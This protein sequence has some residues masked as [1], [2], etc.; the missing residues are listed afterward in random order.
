MTES[1]I[2]HRAE[3]LQDLTKLS[4]DLLIRLMEKADAS[5]GAVWVLDQDQSFRMVISRGEDHR[6]RS[7][8]PGE[9]IHRHEEIFRGTPF[10]EQRRGKVVLN[11]VFLPILHVGVLVALAHLELNTYNE[12]D[13]DG[14]TL[15][16]VRTIAEGYATFLNNAQTLDRMRSNPLRD[17]ESDTYNE[18]FVLDF[19]KRQVTMGNR[20]R[21]RVGLIS[22]EYEGAEYFQKNQSYRLVQAMI[23]D[24]SETLQGILRDYDVVSHVGNF[25]F[26]MGVPE[27]DSLGCRI[28]IERIRRGFGRLSYLGERFERYGLKPHFGFACFPE[29][30]DTAEDLLSKALKN[31]YD[32]RTDSF[33]NS[34]WEKKGFWEMIEA[35]TTGTDTHGLSVLK[36]TEPMMFQ[37]S[38]TYL[39]QEAIINDIIQNPERRGLFY[40][41]TDNVLITEA[42]LAKNTF[43][44]RTA[45]RVGVF[46][47]LTGAHTL[48]DLNINTI[49]IP[50]EQS[51]SFQ[52]ILL[53]TDRVAYALMGVHHRIDD[54]KGFHT[55]H[56][57]LVERLVFKL[58]EEYSLQDQI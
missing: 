12:S 40:I 51:K 44:P 53:L 5:S 29:D 4:D 32:S 57:K 36:D 23:K 15:E 27:T 58:R 13:L 54:W 48:N 39:L 28:T 26:I 31:A 52:F 1:N 20:F 50:P 30:G 38:F 56:D 45:T 14:N 55:S 33:N 35:F 8:D 24:I 47:D 34:Q 3:D 11:S 7:I 2:I 41:G 21:R 49:S 16:D 37:A 43:L 6:S 46:G 42:L 17:L 10:F 25:R 9:I 19:L 18:P 22:L